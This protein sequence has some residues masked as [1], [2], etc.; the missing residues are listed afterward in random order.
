MP[1]AQRED[2]GLANVVSLGDRLA[3]RQLTLDQPTEVRVLVPQSVQAPVAQADRAAASEAV[4]GRSS[5]PGGAE[6][7]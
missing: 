7:T 2:L 6:T 4:C 1:L 3:V 5:R